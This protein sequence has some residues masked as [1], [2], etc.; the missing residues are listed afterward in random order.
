MRKILK[1]RLVSYVIVAFVAL[2]IGL[3]ISSFEDITPPTKAENEQEEIK[4]QKVLEEPEI[5]GAN[6]F[7]DIAAR[8]DPGVVLI[9]SE[10]EVQGG[11]FSDP[12]N[13][14]F[15]RFFFG[16]RL[17]RED[18][19]RTREG[20]G[21]GFIVS[22]DGYIVTNEHVVHNADRVK[23]TVNDFE[24]SIDAEVIFSDFDTDLAILK[25]DEEAL[26]GTNLEV[27]EMGDS[28]KIHPGD[29]AIAIGN[30]FGFEHTVTTGVISAL[31][32]PIDIPTQDSGTRTYSNLIQTDAAI[33]P[34]NS[35]GPLLNIHGQV[36]GI[37]TAVSAQ[38][39]GIG[40]AIPINE[41]KNIVNDLI[42]KGEIVRP[43]LGIIY[44]DM[45]ARSKEG[46]MNYYGLSEL[47]GVIINRVIEDS[48][49]HKAGLRPNDI[50]T[51][52]DNQDIKKID[53]VKNIVEEKEIG[54][55]LKI[56]IIRNGN[57]H[58]IFAE[59]AKRPNKL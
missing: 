59:I 6:V 27:L 5:P 18:Q 16:D 10:T 21:S 28:S 2:M 12:F 30:P 38:G 9:T 54:E 51:K 35:G 37:N 13:D 20:F 39:Q 43:W 11:Q 46:Y 29:W 52:I 8:V 17:P 42:E 14:P 50:I 25:L 31:G 48:P 56:E 44:G 4:E 49:A 45:D 47:N 41:V 23:V 32:R 3:T 19:P 26:N 55:S 33:N 58:M 24:D 7:S 22:E 36:I 1:K 15:L 40:F 34:G 57:S 53:D